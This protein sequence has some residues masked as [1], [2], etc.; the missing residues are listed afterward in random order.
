MLPKRGCT[1]CAVAAAPH[2]CAILFEPG[3]TSKNPVTTAFCAI[4]SAASQR[5]GKRPKTNKPTEQTD[6]ASKPAPA[7]SK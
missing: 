3:K 4:L 1:A 2:G 6:G 5:N 7:A